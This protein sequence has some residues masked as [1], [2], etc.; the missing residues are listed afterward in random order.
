MR[1]VTAPAI[2]D[3]RAGPFTVTQVNDVARVLAT[4]RKLQAGWCTHA[5]LVA[6]SGAT[7]RTVNRDLRALRDAGFRLRSK[8]DPEQPARK[9]WRAAK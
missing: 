9:M 1:L 6:L 7:P 5:E 3:I 2:A 4:L 8:P